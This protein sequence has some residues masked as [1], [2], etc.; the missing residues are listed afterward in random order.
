M[1]EKAISDQ[2]AIVPRC[3]AFSVHLFLSLVELDMPNERKMQTTKL[4]S[5]AKKIFCS[6]K[7]NTRKLARFI[8]QKHNL[9]F[10]KGIRLKQ[11]LQRWSFK[12]LINDVLIVA[13]KTFV[14]IIILTIQK[15]LIWIPLLLHLTLDDSSYAILVGLANGI[16]LLFEYIPGMPRIQVIVKIL[17]I[18]TML[19]CTQL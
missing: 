2:C 9:H 12:C 7:W 5:K 1:F 4:L 6:T 10:E 19:S 14:S 15:N 11:S 16:Q 17:N 13:Q 8:E 3:G 18:Y